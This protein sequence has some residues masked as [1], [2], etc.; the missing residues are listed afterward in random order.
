MVLSAMLPGAIGMGVSAAAGLTSYFGQRDANQKNLQIAQDNRDFQERMSNTAHQRAM[1]DLAAAGLN[2]I[3]AA[4]HGA[5]TP[6]GASA[7][8][9]NEMGSAVSSALDA[10]RTMLE[11]NNIRAQNEKL[12]AETDLTRIMRDVA[13]EDIKIKSSTARN[14]AAQTPRLEAEARMDQ[15]TV[16][17][18]LRWMQRIGASLPGLG[19]LFGQPGYGGK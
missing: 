13:M 8:M 4:R 12:H 5:S 9:Q 1:S 3:L 11:I 16:G 15:T 2:P 7:S 10:R 14:V 6:M 19:G 17:A 18:V